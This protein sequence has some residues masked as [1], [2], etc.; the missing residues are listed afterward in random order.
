[1]DA[2]DLQGLHPQIP[3]DAVVDVNYVVA[4]LQIPVMGKA[5]P[6]RPVFHLMLGR[7]RT[8]FRRRPNISSSRQDH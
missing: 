1:M 4:P 2:A 6:L 7:V 5:G 8:A 3:A